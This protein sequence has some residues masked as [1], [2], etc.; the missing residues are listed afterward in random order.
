MAIRSGHGNGTGQPRIEVVSPEDLPD[1]CRLAQSLPTGERGR[2]ATG[3]PLAALVGKAK[4][5]STSLAVR[6]GLAELPD[7][8]PSALYERATSAL[9]RSQ[10]GDIN[11]KNILARS[12]SC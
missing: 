9:G 4:A 5:C 12:Q 7:R 6:L 1:D 3:N 10:V 8:A 11:A 2:F